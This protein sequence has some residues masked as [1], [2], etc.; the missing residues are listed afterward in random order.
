VAVWPTTSRRWRKLKPSPSLY[1]ASQSII[2]GWLLYSGHLLR[3]NLLITPYY[4]ECIVNMLL[5]KYKKLHR[6][7]LLFTDSLE[8][9]LQ[10]KAKVKVTLRLMVS[11]SVSLCIEPYLGLMTR[12]LFLFHS[13]G[14][15]PVGRSLWREDGSAFCICCWPLQAQS[16]SVPSPLELATIFYCLRFKTFLFVASYNSQGHGGGFDHSSTRF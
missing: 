14:L 12:Y 4:R 9:H 2:S 11:Q 10:L 1:R 3:T 13:Y 6:R 7:N 5:I 8:T 15:V 16:F